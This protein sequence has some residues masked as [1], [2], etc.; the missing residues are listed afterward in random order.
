VAG[1]RVTV[2]TFNIHHGVGTDARLDCARTAAA[3]ERMDVD[4]AGLQEVD[5][6]WSHRSTFAD[7]ARYLAERLGVHLAFTASLRHR[8]ERDVPGEYG[9]A[10]LSRHPVLRTRS[11]LL[12]RPRGGEQRSLLEAAVEV[13]GVVLRCLNTHLE[14]SWAAE[15]RAQA[16]AIAASIARAPGDHDVPTVLLGD[17]N[18]GPGTPEVG[19][20]TGRLADAWAGAGAGAGHT[21]PTAGPCVRIDYVLASPGIEVEQAA[22]LATDAS[23]HLPVTARLRLP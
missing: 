13:D 6:C 16:A 1:V 4:V 8:G 15:R 2:G 17:L 20:L 21:Y 9:V 7:Q 23:D 18:A 12:P 11:M 3:I 14:H 10:L 5:R 19:T 22:V